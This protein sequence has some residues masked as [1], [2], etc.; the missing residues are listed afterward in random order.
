MPSP[1]LDLP[2]LAQRYA[3]VLVLSAHPDDETLG[4]GGLLADLADAGAA[5]SVLVATDGERSHP[6][7]A[8]GPRGAGRPPSA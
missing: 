8:P 3:Q 1:V 5:V 4:V 7:G 2:A 6:T